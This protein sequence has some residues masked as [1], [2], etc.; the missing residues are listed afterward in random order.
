MLHTTL[1]AFPISCFT[2]TLLADIGY[3]RTANLLWLHFGEWLLLAGLVFG[4]LAALALAVD[5]LVNRTRISPIAALVGML[6]LVLATINSFV[7]ARDGWNAVV[8]AG[9]TLSALTVVAML[10]AG[11]LAVREARH[12]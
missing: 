6:A 9:L 4:A 12:A 5:H 2:L 7:H 10:V 3:W 11:W 8:P 1:I